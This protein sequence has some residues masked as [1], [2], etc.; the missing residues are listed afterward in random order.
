M[1]SRFFSKLKRA[2]KKPINIGAII[3]ALILTIFIFL[4]YK[5]D[6]LLDLSSKW[7]ILSS[8]PL[9]VAL[10]VGDHISYFKGFGF[11][12][13]SEVSRSISNYVNE[14]GRENIISIP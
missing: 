14:M 1:F 6:S 2:M 3:S 13:K 8:V 7:V 10:F 12:I 4:D 9:I 5:V 11:E